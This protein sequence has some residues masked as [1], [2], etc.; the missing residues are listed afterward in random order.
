MLVLLIAIPAHADP[1]D[2]CACS[3]NKPGFHRAS[4]LTGDWGGER[5]KLFEHGFK[6]GGAYAPELFAAPGLEGDRFAVAG[7]ASLTLD[8][9]LATLISD[10]LG[11]VHVAGFGIHGDGISQ[12][13]MDVYGVSN[14]VAPRDVRLFE[15]WLEQPV[16]P[17]SVRAGLLSAD[18][19]LIIAEHST[20]LMSGTF[21]IIAM[22][23]ANLGGPVYPIAA[24][25]ASATLTTAEVNVIGAL[26]AGDASEQHGLPTAIGGEALAMGE[27][28]LASLVKLGV[29]H[30]T[31]RGNGYY[32]I[33]DHELEK[34]LGAFARFAWAPDGPVALY[35]DVGIRFRAGPRRPRDFLSVG[36]AFSRT[37]M[38]SQTLTE[39]TYQILVRGWLT[40]QP[41]AQLVMQTTGTSGVVATRAVVAF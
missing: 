4:A 40:I 22:M 23:S 24:P 3:P 36:L 18:Q 31:A 37:E 26:Y 30:H 38:G 27:V 16:G 1:V 17:V 39:A 33:V 14:N 28:E 19:E 13:L 34:Y 5:T 15:A 35:T 8:V 9:D 20:V 6:I 10:G 2:P 7:L 11:Q 21:G 32:A 41:D 12:R 25:G 29:W